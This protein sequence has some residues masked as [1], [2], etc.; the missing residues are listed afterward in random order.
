M[1]INQD[2]RNLAIIAH[3][4][5]LAGYFAAIGQILIP[6]L[7]YL[8]SQR[9]F[10]KAAAKEAL[11]AQISFTIY[12]LIAW[13]SLFV[14][15][16]FVLIPALAIFVIWTMISASLTASRGELYRY[17]LIIRFFS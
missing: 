13:L 12:G 6:L 17:P 1:G 7:I 10:V 2:D 4:A 15:V 16:G 14:L 5:P 11:N 8:L 3:L 9:P